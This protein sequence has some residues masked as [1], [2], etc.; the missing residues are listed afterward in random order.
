MIGVLALII[1]RAV[2]GIMSNS[3]RFG[4]ATAEKAPLTTDEQ[5]RDL[6]S[7]KTPS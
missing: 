4:S 5:F 1:F 2:Y 7:G 3:K 6:M